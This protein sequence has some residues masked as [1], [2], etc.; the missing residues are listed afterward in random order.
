MNRI[1]PLLVAAAFLTIFPH[2]GIAGCNQFF[3]ANVVHHGYQHKA[4]AIVQ[5]LYFAG[6]ATQDE[7][8]Y[9]K[10]FREEAQRLV[11]QLQQMNAAPQQQA[12][13]VLSARCISCHSGESP[14][15]GFSLDGDL[16]SDT[17]TR[18]LEVLAGIN[19]PPG[20]KPVIE[21]LKQEDF[22]ALMNE[23]LSAKS[24]PTEGVLR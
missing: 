11:Q 20:M 17:K 10:A 18:A 23:I 6:Q 8:I 9:R 24:A 22:P 19:V 14:K 1:I 5:P 3:R 21:K 4:V 15:G 7:A 13:S 12:G 2:K 16:S